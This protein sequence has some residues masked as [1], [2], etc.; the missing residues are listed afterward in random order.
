M[1]S[2]LENLLEIRELVFVH[3]CQ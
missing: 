1:M 3:I 2:Y